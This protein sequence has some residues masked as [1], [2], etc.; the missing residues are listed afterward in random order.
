MS[1]PAPDPFQVEPAHHRWLLTTCVAG[2]AGSLIIG[3]A[4]I[5]IFGENAAPRDAY[6][7]VEKAS[8][9][10]NYPD[11]ADGR[12]PVGR[13]EFSSTYQPVVPERD[14]N[15]ANLYPEITADDLP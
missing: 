7:S 9:T 4:V 10:G 14:L 8:L 5:G 13:K 11:T 3:S 6:A 2:I 12:S 1:E 15:N